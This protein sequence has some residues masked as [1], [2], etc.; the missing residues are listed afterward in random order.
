MLS[1]SNSGTIIQ[2]RS[3]CTYCNAVWV[4]YDISQEFHYNGHN[5]KAFG[6][7]V[8]QQSPT[9]PSLGR[10]STRSGASHRGLP[11]PRAGC[12][13]ATCHT[14]CSS[15]VPL[16]HGLQVKQHFSQPSVSKCTQG[17]ASTATPTSEAAKPEEAGLGTGSSAGRGGTGASSHLAPKAPAR[18]GCPRNGTPGAR[19]CAAPGPGPQLLGSTAP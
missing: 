19:S 12:D 8:S 14:C 15:D 3:G 1:I 4:C 2:G 5:V 16:E 11:Q 10:T 18:G 6:E 7:S 17:R 9:P 13:R